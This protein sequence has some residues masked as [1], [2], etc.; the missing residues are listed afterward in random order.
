MSLRLSAWNISAP[1]GLIFVK[2][3]IFDGDWCLS[4]GGGGDFYISCLK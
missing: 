2:F 1:T 3:D 4:S